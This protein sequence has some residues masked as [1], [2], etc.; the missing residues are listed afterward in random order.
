MEWWL[1]EIVPSMFGAIV[2]GVVVYLAVT[3]GE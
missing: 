1:A 2:G 3:R